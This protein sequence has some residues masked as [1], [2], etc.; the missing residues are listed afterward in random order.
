MRLD[1]DFDLFVH[2]IV[3]SGPGFDNPGG[4]SVAFQNSGQLTFGQSPPKELSKNNFVFW[5]LVR[6]HTV[7]HCALDASQSLSKGDFE[8]VFRA[9][10]RKIR[11]STGSG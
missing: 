2:Q 6:N 3:P 9:Q 8:R 10:S 1:G 11:P 4:A 5:Q 7:L